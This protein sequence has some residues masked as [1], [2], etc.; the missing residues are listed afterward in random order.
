MRCTGRG[1]ILLWGGALAVSP[2]R[3]DPPPGATARAAVLA[4]GHAD[5]AS[6]ELAARVRDEMSRRGVPVLTTE[7]TRQGLRGGPAA[8]PPCDPSRVRARLQDADRQYAAGRSRESLALVDQ[9]LAC[10]DGDS[11][12]TLEKAALAHQARLKSANVLLTLAGSA[13]VGRGNTEAG[14]Q[15]KQRLVEALRADP[16]MVMPVAEFTPRLRLLLDHA[17][18]ELAQA[19][20][21]ALVVDSEPPGIPVFMEGREV[22]ATPLNL[23]RAAPHG[24]S[25]VWLAE[26][27]RRSLQHDLEV[28]PGPGVLHVDFDLEA[29]ADADAPAL[30]GVPTDLDAATA[31]RLASRLDVETLV[32]VARSGPPASPWGTATVFLR[33]RGLVAR[34]GAVS[35]ATADAAPVLAEFAALGRWDARI[36]PCG[37]AQAGPGATRPLL[38]APVQSVP[39]GFPAAEVST[40]LGDALAQGWEIRPG[41]VAP[42]SC[43]DDLGCWASWGRDGGAA[44]VVVPRALSRAGEWWLEVSAVDVASGGREGRVVTREV[45]KGSVPPLVEAL[46]APGVA[47]TTLQATSEVEGVSLWVDGVDTGVVASTRLL[48]GLVPGPHVVRA[49]GAG[50]EPVEQ[51]V[52]L[53]ADR[54]VAVTV[55]R[56]LDGGRLVLGTDNGNAPTP[57]P[58]PARR[59]P[60]LPTAWAPPVLLAGVASM[61]L[62]AAPLLLGPL[63]SASAGLLLLRVYPTTSSGRYLALDSEDATLL[64]ARV[65]ATTA[66]VPGGLAVAALGLLLVVAGVVVM[67]AGVVGLV[68]RLLDPP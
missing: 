8:G 45:A 20:R 68:A 41:P 23:A 7:E 22:G 58:G 67:G 37:A 36:L 55:S 49:V 38:L 35:L 18:A 24:R 54:P 60:R 31:G 3:A 28:G 47:R 30:R 9:A 14:R 17:R 62:G 15:A 4:V 1:V 26:G 40:Q 39:P 65:Y 34:R 43:G 11:T 19:P 53:R 12:L 46:L 32:L 44:T 33:S 6:L 61:A 13:E 29:R 51:V 2:A 59:G 64:T 56:A 16:G 63:A 10:L 25:R 66:A 5:A 21:E 57:A 27:A 42:G 52:D 50:L 48:E